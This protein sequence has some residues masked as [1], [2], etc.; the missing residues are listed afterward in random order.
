M[1]STSGSP[2]EGYRLSPHQKN[3]WTLQ[4]GTEGDP[5]RAFSSILI[6]G[7]LSVPHLQQAIDLVVSRHEI[8]RTTFNRPPG[9]K[10][11][12]Q[13][14]GEAPQ[15]SWSL[16]KRAENSHLL[17]LSLPSLC[18]DSA[19]VTN[20]IR[21]LCQ[22]YASKHDLPAEPLQYADFAEWQNELL[23]ANDENA[24]AGKDHWGNLQV[25]PTLSLPL[26]KRVVQP[27]LFA[28]D[29][30]AV[31][32]SSSTAEIEA[33]AQEQ[34]TSV[35]AV[36]FACWEALLW[37]L[38]GET[39]SMF[40]LHFLS[41]GRNSE[42]L[43]DAFGLYAKYLPIACYCKDEPFSE[44]LRRVSD[45]LKE[46][47]EWQEHF[48]PSSAPGGSVLYDFEERDGSYDAGGLSF[49]V[50]DQHACFSSFKLKLSCVLSDATLFS[51]LY[52]D[53]QIFDAQAVK[54]IATYFQRFLASVVENPQTALGDIE[55]IDAAE[56]RRLLVELNETADDFIMSQTVHEMFEAQVSRNP[57]ALA[58]VCGN[59]QLTYDELNARA[60]QLAHLLRR[61]GAGPDACIGLCVERSVEMIVALLG[62]LKAGGAYVPLNPDHPPERLAIQ[63]AESRSSVLITSG[64]INEEIGFAGETIDLNRERALLE[65]E[66]KHN[67]PTPTT[68]KNLVYIIYTSGSTGI[69]KGVAVRHE[70]L[71][72]YTRFILKRLEVKRPLAFATVST[73]SA[74]L[75]NT[76]IFPAL[77]SGGC[78]HIIGY[79]ASME[80]DLLR[81]YFTNHRIDVLKIVPSH[82]NALLATQ[83]DGRI[84]PAEYLIVGGE[85]LTWDLIQNISRLDHTCRIINHYGP[86]ETTVGSL[87]FSVEESNVDSSTVP[88][89]RPIANT[90]C[91]ILD[92]RQRPVPFGVSGELYISG[93]GV[94]VGYLNRPGETAER[95]IPDPFS[96]NSDSRLYRTGDLVRYL[97]GN[98]IEFLGR[99]DRQ[100]KVR[101]YRVEL[102]E[103]EA[104]LSTHAGVCQAVVTLNRDEAG[105]DRIVA[106]LV[107]APIPHEQLRAALKQKLPDYMVPA[108]F[109]FL[110]SLPLTPNGKV[111][112]AALPAPDD[113]RVGLQ[114]DF[115]APRSAVEKELAG[116]WAGLLKVNAVGV[117]DNFFDLGGHSLLATQLV[118]RMRKEFQM[119]IPLR[120]LFET[121]TVAALAEK[122]E[123]ATADNLTRLLAELDQIDDDEAARI[124]GLEKG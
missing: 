89:G 58:L 52:Y 25:V 100:V 29:S 40:V 78:L 63:L 102:D 47:D 119:E 17:E 28:P 21:E 77:L 62:I 73:I 91:Y 120:S 98:N 103:I 109:V 82:L 23:E 95:F 12:F 94:A 10:L 11:P 115:V 105:N 35:S 60:N 71:I 30:I 43:A 59:Q 81:E 33:L 114:M 64:T 1:D 26:E 113:T 36:L 96:V 6:E 48:D 88:I 66:P 20:L 121:P 2:V 19:T 104:V 50:I 8:L 123:Q 13:V 18:G 75:G 99:I 111:N 72:N 83:A 56:R 39:E 49:S 122:I 24:T 57:D 38:T 14:I 51:K 42:D 54:Q 93:A 67:P 9:L 76:C 87:T 74:D 53:A 116:M 101:G 124:L 118:S 85:A 15:L 69:P 4:Q 70:N 106:Y 86:T 117:H 22:V 61:R 5:F 32:L 3:L 46:A 97:P 110:K 27:R 55:L 92:R 79:D 16:T 34:G 41:A 37:R 107:S 84:L 112:R 7:E 44:H 65:A 68:A 108:A 90:R 31:D 80:G 45:E